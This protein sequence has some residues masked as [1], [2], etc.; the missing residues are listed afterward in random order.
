MKLL[1]SQAYKLHEENWDADLDGLVRL[2]V[3]K[4]G[5]RNEPKVP[6]PDRVVT[7]KPLTPAKLDQALKD[8]PGWE[9]VDSF[10][11]GDYPKTRHE[12][13]KTYVFRSFREAMNFMFA[14]IPAI[15]ELQHHPRWENQW[16]SVTVYLSTWDIDSQISHLDLKLAKKLDEIH[17][18]AGRQA[19][20]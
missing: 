6:A 1:S 5:F 12:L 11:P 19:R 3:E 7:P 8:L 15:Q 10:I 9:Q 18:K 20:E 13:R 2:L 16:R 17:A 4:Y 14:A